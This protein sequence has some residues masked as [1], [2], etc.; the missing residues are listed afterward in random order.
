[1][2]APL[3][4]A[5]LRYLGAFRLP[6]GG[7]VPGTFALGGTRFAL[8]GGEALIT[9]ADGFQHA[10]R[11]RLPAPRVESDP[12][13]LPVAE[14]AGPWFDPS[15]GFKTPATRLGGL[16]YHGGRLVVSVHEYYDADGT[17]T[18]TH[19]VWVDGR[20]NGLFT[21][22]GLPAAALAGSMAPIPP[23]W[24]GALG[25]PTLS[26][27]V[28]MPIASRRSVNIAL[29]AFDP[30][31]LGS[32]SSRAA[33]LAFNPLG[34]GYG[35]LDADNPTPDPVWNLT[36]EPNGCAFLSRPD[37]RAAVLVTGQ[38]G[39]GRTWYGLRSVELPDGPASDP[40]RVYK[41]NHSESY[42]G[43]GWWFDPADLSA[44]R[45]RKRKPADVRP[46]HAGEL[47]GLYPGCGDLGGCAADPE[48]GRLYVVQRNVYRVG[49]N[50][51]PVVHVYGV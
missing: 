5:D 23:E 4:P 51:L 42:A 44:V 6:G 50:R 32:L 10:A 9:G 26:A 35:N 27:S 24:Q 30:A 18:A 36:S 45:A 38:H 46:F 19:G 22:A 39:T 28:G 41:G 3:Q 7:K 48:A 15:G 8:D 11:V 47:P 34:R 1:M 14:F 13:A 16:L 43:Y 33:V 17:A 29:A 37:G 49:V 2:T 12:A 31:A 21:L 25:G 20:V 40:C